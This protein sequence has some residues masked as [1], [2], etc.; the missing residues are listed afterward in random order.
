MAERSAIADEL[1]LLDAIDHLLATIHTMSRLHT[2][3]QEQVQHDLNYLRLRMT[4]I[5]SLMA[6][7][8]QSRRVRRRH[9]RGGQ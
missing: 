4:I 8:R 7:N 9:R 1:R 6:T 5:E 2:L 3:Q